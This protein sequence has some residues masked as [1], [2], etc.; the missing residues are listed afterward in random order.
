[1]D[2]EQT[3]INGRLRDG[4]IGVVGL[5]YVGL[6]LA[7]AA[8]L[9]GT[10]TVGYDADADRISDLRRGHDR[11]GMAE[12]GELMRPEMEF[13]S[14]VTRLGDCAAVLIAVPTPVDATSRPDLSMLSDACRA[15][16]GVL[17]RDSLVVVEST[18]FPGTTRDVCVPILERA[19]GLVCG[20]DFLV[21][22]SPERIN[23][24]DNR[25]RL[26]NTTKLIA[27][28]TRQS[29]TEATELYGRFVRA[30]LCAATTVES[31]E[32][33]KLVENCQRDVNIA[34]VN[35]VAQIC[36]A[37][38]LASQEVLGLAGSKWNFLPFEPGLV[39]GHCIAVD[40]YYLIDGVRNHGSQ[41]D[42][43]SAARE[44]NVAMPAFVARRVLSELAATGCYP[45]DS[46][47]GV[48]GVTYK[49]DVPDIRNSGVRQLTDILQRQGVQVRVVDPLIGA[50]H[51]V[52]DG[53]T[54]VA[55]PELG[56]VDCLVYA[57][58]HQPIAENLEHIVGTHL[59]PD[60]VFIDLTGRAEKRLIG[61]GQRAWAL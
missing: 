27:G 13:T 43:L 48:L 51:N 39:G 36:D 6:P 32:L 8:A 52:G 50:G 3:L 11:N 38:G 16:G 37:L 17:R 46:K 18:V 53:I 26:A 54:T 21:A 35:E 47:V 12:A 14:D 49:H 5:G 42:L 59:R 7:V 40:P 1:V 22:Y 23:P 45:S 41:A 9:S 34:F 57:V 20:A 28:L 55:L 61:P 4:P 24:G 60:G 31:A 2:Y 15:L 33:A 29:L 56:E 25:H 58:A 44:V 10:R 30:E 19:S